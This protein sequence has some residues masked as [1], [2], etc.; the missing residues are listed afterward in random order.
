[1][2]DLDGNCPHDASLLVHAVNAADEVIRLR[3]RIAY[4]D[5]MLR[6]SHVPFK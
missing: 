6:E 3:E 2:R 5:G 1:V 4:L